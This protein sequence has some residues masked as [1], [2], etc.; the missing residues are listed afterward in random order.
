MG[1]DIE[2]AYKAG[3]AATFD[4]S[5]YTGMGATTNRGMQGLLDT[6]N[7]NSGAFQGGIDYTRGLL[8]GGGLAGGQQ[9]NISTVNNIAGQYGGIASSAQSPSLTEQTLMARARGDEA[10]NNPYLDN[11]I[12]QTND[13]AYADVMASLG[14]SG[15]TGSNVHMETL[16]GTLADNESRL[17]YGDYDNAM[18]RQTEA[19]GMIEG[20][21]QQGL[22]NRMS[23]LNAQAGTAGNA[24]GM[25]QQGVSNAIGAASAMPALYDAALAPSQTIL[26]VGQAQDAD[27]QAKRLADYELFQR[28]SDPAF[29]HLAKYQGL[30]GAQSGNPQPEQQPGLFDWLGLGIAGAGTFL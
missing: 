18:R 7:R 13:S 25:E 20:Q 21:R 24:F 17:R 8:S 11:I 4:K 27:A 29:Q 5:L 3:P 15:R 23:A 12:S 19:L 16:G 30:L 22:L 10:T 28:R 2:A 9:G 6:A 14:G 1:S 26:G